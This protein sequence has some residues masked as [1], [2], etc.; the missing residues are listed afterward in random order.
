MVIHIEY[1][2]VLKPKDLNSQ[3]EGSIEVKQRANILK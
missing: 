2:S 3:I 1:R